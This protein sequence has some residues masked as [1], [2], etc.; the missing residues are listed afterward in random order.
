M[1]LIAKEKTESSFDPIPEGTYTG[2]C[3][4]LVD[5]GVHYNQSFGTKSEKVLIG[6]VIPDETYV[7]KDGK[8]VPRSLTQEY[9]NSLSKK[10]N[11][12]PMLASWRGKEFTAEELEGFSL[13]NIVGKACLLN[14]IHKQTKAGK[15]FSAVAG[16]MRLPKGMQSPELADTPILFDFDTDSL[17]QL[18]ALPEWIR[19]KVKQSETYMDRASAQI[20]GDVAAGTTPNLEEIPGGEDEL[21]F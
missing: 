17:D 18:E 15:V 4:M 14:I 1:S 6:W 12:R 10:S 19:N 20:Q 5:L 7:N 11:L 2:V 9:T 3:N 13:R 21:P 16:V 8:T